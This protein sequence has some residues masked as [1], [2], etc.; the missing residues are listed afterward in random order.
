MDVWVD[1]QGRVR[2]LRSRI[3]FLTVSVAPSVVGPLSG[4]AEQVGSEGSVAWTV[5]FYDF[6]VPVHVA[7]PPADQV[8]DF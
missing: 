8:T 2:K 7:I 6:G 5:E 1:G 4:P 3:D